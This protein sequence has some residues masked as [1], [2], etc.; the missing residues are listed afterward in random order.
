M[1]R[2][3]PAAGSLSSLPSDLL[4]QPIA[5][6][7]ARLLKLQKS[8]AGTRPAWRLRAQTPM[9]L[10]RMRKLLPANGPIGLFAPVEAWGEPVDLE[11]FLLDLLGPGRAND[12]AYPAIDA[13]Q[14]QM[15]FRRCRLTETVAH[16]SWP[17]R[18]APP[19]APECEPSLV[20][21]PCVAADLQ[22]HRMGR[23]AGHF[24][25]FLG[26]H[27]SCQAWG[28]L[29]SDYLTDRFPSD[30]VRPWDQHVANLLTDLEF[31]ETQ[32]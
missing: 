19:Q 1:D 21:A 20:F 15:S 12:F 31:K 10:E 26:S 29:R 18:E 30:W 8:S 14:G 3:K 17:V 28:V 23:G 5:E 6:A 22:G 7:R 27:P 11:D 9:G 4:Q 16:P 25:R 24:D 32:L 2:T 13:V